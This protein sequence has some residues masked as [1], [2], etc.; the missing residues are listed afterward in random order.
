MRL[1]TARAVDRTAVLLF[2]VTLSANTYHV[3]SALFWERALGSHAYAVPILLAITGLFVVFTPVES[4]TARSRMTRNVTTRQQVL[5]AFGRLLELGR[6]VT[7]PLGI[8]DLGLHVWARRRTLRH[9]V[10]GVLARIAT[11]R[12]GTNPMNRPF[13]PPKGV[14]VVGLCWKYDHEVGIDVEQLANS[15]DDQDKFNAYRDKHG[16]DAVMNLTWD[17]FTRIR[18]RGAVFA[19]PIR[20]GRNR[21]VGCLSVDTSH[22]FATLDQP[23]LKAQMGLL[24]IVIGQAGLFS[25][26]QC[27]I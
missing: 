1:A 20:D 19:F 12:V 25:T 21:F 6:T 4:L 14:G 27:M 23:E 17:Q 2:T 22:G 3:P 18:H 11:Y 9:P 5:T 16:P 24:T 26:R 7:P 15:L 8:S 10:S 13:A